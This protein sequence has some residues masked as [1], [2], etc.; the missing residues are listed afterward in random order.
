M[1]LGFGYPNC[2]KR[3][4]SCVKSKWSCTKNSHYKKN[5]IQRQLFF[6]VKKYVT[7]IYSHSI[8]CHEKSWQFQKNVTM[9]VFMTKNKYHKLVFYDNNNCH[10]LFF[11]TTNNCH[12]LHITTVTKMS[13]ILILW[14]FFCQEYV[15]RDSFL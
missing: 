10:I 15:N 4:L 3:K 14:H 2:A 8:A 11:V 13:R 9:C 5:G 1:L 7:V 6:V 12:N